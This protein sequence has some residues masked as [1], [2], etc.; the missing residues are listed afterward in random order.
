MMIRIP[1]VSDRVKMSAGEDM[2]RG[3]MKVA[4]LLD[5]I[6]CGH[7]LPLTSQEQSTLHAYR[8]GKFKLKRGEH[9]ID[10]PRFL[11]SARA[12]FLLRWLKRLREYLKQDVAEKALK[13]LGHYDLNARTAERAREL[14]QQR[15]RELQREYGDDF[16]ELPTPLLHRYAKG[17]AVSQKCPPQIADLVGGYCRSQRA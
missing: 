11:Q 1:D 6:S 15:Q 4:E 7:E 17:S 10:S 14:L 9:R 13:R 5:R 8:N 2:H 16:V 3:T 12:L